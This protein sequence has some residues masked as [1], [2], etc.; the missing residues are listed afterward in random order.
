[1]RLYDYMARVYNCMIRDIN[2]ST[3]VVHRL[4]N[5]SSQRGKQQRFPSATIGQRSIHRKHFKSPTMGST[6]LSDRNRHRYKWNVQSLG[7]SSWD[8][9]CERGWTQIGSWFK[10]R[11]ERT[12]RAASNWY[13]D[14]E[15][16]LVLV[17]HFWT[18][19]GNRA[20]KW[21]F[22]QFAYGKSI[23][24]R[25]NKNIGISPHAKQLEIDCSKRWK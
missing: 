14:K 17:V 18:K 8:L 10:A 20:P 13:E 9:S 21:W 22:F 11:I 25:V 24:P 6:L 7:T 15:L 2:P 1:M 3:S 5:F 12:G 19:L 23:Q 16:Q 4:Q